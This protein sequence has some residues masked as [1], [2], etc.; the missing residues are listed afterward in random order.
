MTAQAAVAVPAAPAAPRVARW[1]AARPGG[2]RVLDAAELAAAPDPAARLAAAAAAARPA[3]L[4][5][6]FRNRESAAATIAARAGRPAAP[7]LSPREVEAWIAAAG[8]SVVERDGLASDAPPAIAAD[9]DALL[10]RLLAELDPDAGREWLLWT[11]GEAP[12]PAVRVPDLLTVVMRHHDLGRLELLDQAVF[13][14]AAQD[15][16]P[17]E[18][19]VATQ[20]A[21]A[22]APARIEEV[23]RRHRALGGYASRVVRV[24]AAGDA[25]ARAANA[26]LRAA[27][28]RYV[29]LLDDDDVV[30]PRH[31]ARLVEALRAGGNAWAIA[32]AR[33]ARFS[34]GPDGA[35]VCLAK[36]DH[37][38]P[39]AFDL[40]RLLHA[41]YAPSHAFV[42]D[43][44]RIGR[45]DL[46]LPEDLDRAEDYALVL[47]LAALFRPA[48]VDAAGC[49]YRLRDD[50]TNANPAAS[51]APGAWAETPEG[52]ARAEARV[53]AAKS[54]L[55]VLATAA[56]LARAA[57]ADRPIFA[58]A[59]A[60]AVAAAVAPPPLRHRLA[61]RLND[62]VKSA[63]PALHGGARR[64]ARWMGERG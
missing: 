23:L 4:A 17:L 60:P 25:R 59:A 15:Y 26:G 24:D 45:F 14:L 8:L 16:R 55:A 12:A 58:D 1:L 36:A 47:R 34:R 13:S 11:V 27:R 30:Y 6:L 5:L 32:R 54:G 64:L 49:E 38:A 56:D 18:I 3:A 19:V 28:G 63:A 31:Y 61:D 48:W 10:R 39:A 44:D 40:P 35:L 7:G 42:V 53:A 62:V 2:A 41:N 20:C 33:V 43:R 51:A 50:G 21:A 9:A 22:D 57:E 52:W 46:S 37:P 29:A